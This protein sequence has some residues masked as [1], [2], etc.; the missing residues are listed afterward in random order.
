MSAQLLQQIFKSVYGKPSWHV[1]RRF[2][3]SVLLEFGK[4]KLKI[5]EKNLQPTKTGRKFPERRVR[6]YGDWHLTIFDCDW[7][8]RQ[9]NYKICN[10]RSKTEAIDQGCEIL[11]G[12]I[13]TKVVVHPKTFITDFFFDLGGHLQ[14]KPFKNE[15]ETSS[16]WDLFCPNGR[17]FSL[18][19][20]GNYSY[21]SGKTPGEK[22]HFSPFVFDLR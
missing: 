3:P 20:D 15:R 18:M 16:M 22:I 17:V 6:V 8:I 1:R 12:Q 7:E 2:G 14:T 10:S 13:L 9:N 11:D 4:P 19:S 5:W 21:A